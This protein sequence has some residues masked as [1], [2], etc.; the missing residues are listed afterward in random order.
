MDVVASLYAGASD[1]TLKTY[2]SE[3]LF[4]YSIGRAVEQ[5]DPNLQTGLGEPKFYLNNTVYGGPWGRPQ[6]DGPA[7]AAITL[8]EF[9]NT[10]LANGGNITVIKNRIYDS[11]ANPTVAPVMRDLL[12]VAN[13]WTVT[14]FDLW[15]EE[16]SD[17][18]YTKMVQHRALIMG[19]T[20]ASKMGDA[21]TSTTLSTAAKALAATMPQFWDNTRN[22]I[23]YEYGP[24]LAGKYSYKDSAVVLGV[25]HGYA[26]DGLYGPTDPKVLSSA[27][28]IA[29]SFLIYPIS[30]THYDSQ[31]R[32]LGIPIGRYPED[33]YN[34]VGTSANGGNPWYL[35]TAAMAELFYRA[36]ASFTATGK[37]QVTANSFAFW[38]YFAPEAPV[39][40]GKT[41]QA[42]DV[43][44]FQ[45]VNSLNGWGD[46]FMRTISYYT[47]AGGHLS[48]EIN[49]NTGVAQGAIDLTWSYASVITAA[50]AR[51]AAMNNQEAAYWTALA[52]IPV[53]TNSTGLGA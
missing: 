39:Y 45:M 23:L 25:L 19:A 28:E 17:H 52:N 6:N 49:R 34:G 13:N 50:A 9:S 7:T 15:E 31:G 29:T 21:A 22:L 10:Y 43:E 44:F 2:Y 32:V 47:P 51:A 20:F 36:S 42:S 14:S 46:A 33:V 16:R 5:N 38:R 11:A 27:L 18:F 48:E 37:I 30:A 4:N 12:F 8:M 35:C 40:K 1:V 41:Y 53:T 26:N 3:L 24:V